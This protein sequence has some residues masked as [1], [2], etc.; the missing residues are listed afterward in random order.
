[1]LDRDVVVKVLTAGKLGIEGKARLLQEAQV[2]G[3]LNHPNIVA[4]YDV[5]TA[6]TQVPP[7]EI[8]Y[9]V[10]EYV[11]GESLAIYHAAAQTLATSGGLGPGR[12][13]PRGR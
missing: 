12:R 8:S 10:M 2:V 5:G 6:T 3:S 4:I 9:I 13:S 11:E 1:M 7:E